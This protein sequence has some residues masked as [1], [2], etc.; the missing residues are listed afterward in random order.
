M[1]KAALSAF[2]TNVEG[3]TACVRDA[4]IAQNRRVPPKIRP[5][6]SQD[7][8]APPR[9]SNPDAGDAGMHTKAKPGVREGG[10]AANAESFTPLQQSFF[11][12]V[13]SSFKAWKLATQVMDRPSLLC[14]TS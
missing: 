3:T 10:Y 4:G 2:S 5:E 11:T 13:S 8:A 7:P 6:R 1:I 12:K 9:K 14:V